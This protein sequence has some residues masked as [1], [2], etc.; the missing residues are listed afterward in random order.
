MTFAL[1]TPTPPHVPL[2]D[3]TD[4]ERKIARKC[5][6]LHA[7]QRALADQTLRVLLTT[8]AQTAVRDELAWDAGDVAG[9]INCLSAA[10]Y[11]DSEWCL[12][13]GHNG[14]FAPM[15]ADSYCMGYNRFKGVENQRTSPW[16]YVKFTIRIGSMTMLVFSA[17][18]ERSL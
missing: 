3:C 7:V 12:P 5:W 14:R 9:F 10:R 1:W 17:H 2:E 8:S 13:S 6:D 11:L 16:V 18:P 4:A 15:A